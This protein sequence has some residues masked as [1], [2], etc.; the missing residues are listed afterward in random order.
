MSSG[1]CRPFCLGLNMLKRPILGVGFHHRSSPAVGW[2]TAQLMIYHLLGKNQRSGHKSLRP[3]VG[4]GLVIKLNCGIAKGPQSQNWRRPPAARNGRQMCGP[5]ASHSRYWCDSI[6]NN[7]GILKKWDKL[8]LAR[9][10]L[11]MG[12]VNARRCYYIMPSLIGRTNTQM[13]PVF[14]C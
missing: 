5:S 9:I 2:V 11:V 12:S 4:P 3:L 7:M 6:N 13:I 14:I 10:N 8:T 1:K